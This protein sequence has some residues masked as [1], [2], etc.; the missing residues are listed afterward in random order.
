[1]VDL[2]IVV[3]WVMS[4]G[5]GCLLFIVELQL[6]L[7][8]VVLIVGLAVLLVG[9]DCCLTAA[10]LLWVLFGFTILW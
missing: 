6:C 1:M 2:L 8:L 9:C 4:L 5:F 7:S 3:V 10:G